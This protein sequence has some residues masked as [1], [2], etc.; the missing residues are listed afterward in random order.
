MSDDKRRAPPPRVRHFEDKLTGREF[1]ELCGVSLQT[2]HNWTKQR[3]LPVTRTLGRRLRISARRVYH[4]LVEKGYPIP[5]G[6]RRDG[7]PRGLEEVRAP[8]QPRARARSSHTRARMRSR[9]R[10]ASPEVITLVVSDI[11]VDEDWNG[12]SYVSCG[13]GGKSS[14][15]AEL[16]QALTD[17]Q[18]RHDIEERGLLQPPCVRRLGDAWHLVFGFRRVRACIAIDPDMEIL[19]TV[20]PAPDDDSEEEFEALAANLAEN[21]HRRELRSFER[22][23]VLFRMQT[24]RPDLSHGD[25]ARRVGLSRSYVSSLIRIRTRA[26]PEIWKLFCTHGLRFGSGITYRDLLAVIKLERHDEQ[27][28]AWAALVEARTGHKPRQKAKAKSDPIGTRVSR[29]QLQIY[30]AE[31]EHLPIDERYRQGVRYGLEVAL[32]LESWEAAAAAGTA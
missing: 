6:A 17:E 9:A 2:V 32:G 13:T 4:F 29:E 1:A 23:E 19:C 3:G 31:L 28:K 26:A 12:R 25:I 24:L 5:R 16:G 27:R 21:V 22:A 30:L 10:G 15:T 18:L 8:N 11:V 14:G 20:Q 7:R